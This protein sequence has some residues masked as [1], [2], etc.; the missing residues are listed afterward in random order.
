LEARK[1]LVI[2]DQPASIVAPAI[3]VARSSAI[4]AAY[5]PGPAMCRI[6]DRYP[7]QR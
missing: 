4:D 5:L 3:A 1:I 7:G 2:V 6:A